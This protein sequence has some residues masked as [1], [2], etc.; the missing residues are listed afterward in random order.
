APPGPLVTPSN[1][2]PLVS[3]RDEIRSD[4]P[5]SFTRFMEI[6]LY[7]PTSGY[8]RSAQAR[9]GRE[10]DFLTAPEPHSIFGRAI[11]RFAAAVHAA[12]GSPPAFAIREYGAGEGA[13]AA[14]LV[15]ALLDPVEPPPPAPLLLPYL[16]D[17]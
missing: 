1:R 14:P 17:E 7:D 5:M 9:P 11:A 15:A 13:L 3:I 4:G 12:I 6:A 16:V 8:Y 10:G 2:P